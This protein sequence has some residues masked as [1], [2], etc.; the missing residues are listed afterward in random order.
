MGKKFKNSTFKIL[1]DMARTREALRTDGHTRN[2][3]LY[4]SP[5]GN[6]YD[7]H[8]EGTFMTSYDCL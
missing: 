3:D 5:A 8:C 7:N 1:G 4:M 2:Q 6:E